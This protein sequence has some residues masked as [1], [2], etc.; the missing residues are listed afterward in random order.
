MIRC[1][2]DV[3]MLFGLNDVSGLNVCEGRG[4]RGAHKGKAERA[5][6]SAELI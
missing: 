2:V 3:M 4:L 6:L 1:V 5:D